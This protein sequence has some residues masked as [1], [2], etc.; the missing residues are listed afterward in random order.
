MAF[1]KRKHLFVL[2]IVALLGLI[3]GTVAAHEGREVGEYE[4][5]FGWRVEPA[6]AG[7]PNGPELYISLH[8]EHEEE[9]ADHEHEDE[10]NPMEGVEV[11]LQVEVTFGPSSR[12]MEMRPAFGEIG[13]YV[14]DMIP[15]RPGDYSFRVF[16]TIGDAEIDEVFT[17]A[18][19]SFSS[20]EPASD[21]TFPDELPSVV[22][23]LAR[24]A[25]LEAQI[26]A[27]QS[28]E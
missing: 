13:H 17:S 16:G 19:G 15:T 6:L 25:E 20:V 23:L 26:E 18:D 2:I 3:I 11:A 1:L 8:G 10:V 7:Y 12:T 9:E 24:I 5:V 22:D 21:V 4:L 28:G 27:L 14:A